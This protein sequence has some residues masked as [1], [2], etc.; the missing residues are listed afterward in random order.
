LNS[1]KQQIPRWAWVIITILAVILITG[2]IRSCAK[3][4]A[5]KAIQEMLLRNYG[6]AIQDYRSD[7]IRFRARAQDLV[8]QGKISQQEADEFVELVRKMSRIVP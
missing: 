2:Q 5:K 8:R 1:E 4:D 7:P 3:Q 6:D